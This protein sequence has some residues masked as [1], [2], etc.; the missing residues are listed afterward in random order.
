ME[1]HIKVRLL[2]MRQLLRQMAP[3]ERSLPDN[4]PITLSAQLRT[5]KLSIKT[6]KCIRGGMDGQF[7]QESGSS[8]PEINIRSRRQSSTNGKSNGTNASVTSV[9]SPNF[10]ALPISISTNRPS[11]VWPVFAGFMSM[12]ATFR[13]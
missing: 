5:V 12:W 6:T 7:G 3:N 13:R 11:Q 2:T 4:R 1:H 10:A 8:Q 9:S